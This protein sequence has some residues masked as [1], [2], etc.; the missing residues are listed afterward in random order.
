MS[1]H[2]IPP[3][4]LPP[5]IDSDQGPENWAPYK[6]RLQFEVADFLYHCNQMSGG[7]IN[8]VLNLWAVSLAIHDDDPPF[9][10]A[11]HMYDTINSTP[12]GEV[13]WESFTLQYDGPQPTEN[14]PSWMDSEY[15]I[16]FQNPLSLVHNILSNPEFKSGF[17]YSPFQERTSHGADIIAEDPEMH[18]LVFCPIILGSDKTTILVAR[19]HNEY[20][21]VYLSIGNICNNFRRV[22]CNGVVFLGF[23][24]IPKKNH[25]DNKDARFH[26]FCCQ[27]F[28]S[29]LAKILVSLKPSMT[30]PNIARFPD[31]HYRKTVY[32]LGPYIAD[33]PEQALLACTVQGWC[34]KCT[35]PAKGLDSG[36]HVCCSQ[37][38]SELLVE[39]FELGT[40]W[41]EYGLVGDPF[42]SDFPHAD[43]NELL[44]PDLLHQL[45]KGAFKDHLITWVNNYI[46]VEYPESQAWKILDDI[47]WHIALA[48]SFAW[49]RCFP[50]GRNFKQWTGDDSKALMKVYLPA[51]EGHVL[52]QMVQAMRTF[53]EFCYIARRDVHDTHSIKA[54]EDALQ[55]FHHHRK[56][57]QETGAHT[58]GFDNLPRQHLLVHD[59]RLIRAF[60]A[61]NG[62]CSSIMESKHIKA[63][64][65]P[66]QC[67]N[68]FEVLTQMLLTNQHLDKLAASRVNFTKCGMLEGM[69]L[70]MTWEQILGVFFNHLLT[71][72]RADTLCKV[73]PNDMAAELEGPD[74]TDLIQQ[75]IRDQEHPELDFDTSL[76][77]LPSFYGKIIVYPSAVATFY[78][79]SDLSGVGGMRRE[80]LRA[81][82]SWRNG[83]GHYDTVF[84][85][86]D[87][88]KTGMCGLSVAR[89]R[90]FFSFTHGGVQY[91]CTLVCWLSR[92]GDS[93]D[94]NTGMWVVEEMDDDGDKSPVAI[95]HLDTIVHAAHL[96]PVFGSEQVS[97]TLSFTDTLDIFTSF[98]VNK[99]TDHH[100][101]K[102]AF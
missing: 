39:E 33:Y 69:C 31:G 64:K 102:I 95:L 89:V 12:L 81:V 52:D 36:K 50:E 100:S 82:K 78:A 77:D 13:P 14:I 37:A 11:Q 59:M 75:F 71:F 21:P 63:M 96:L 28:H 48:P 86:T 24:A 2:F 38:H 73:Y 98:Y 66:W 43:I 54:L 34:P 35:A 8:F 5:A 57:F 23:L 51:I 56:I 26:K 9:S 47:D 22:H 70:L 1:S 87:P 17:D 62:L 15:D 94:G 25:V 91:P 44:S 74:F 90:L 42:T 49:L 99:Y 19:G 65:E 30:V 53:L 58:K 55:R 29:S 16:W 67:S 80:C 101:F 61:P 46:K 45:I 93:S 84:I 76:A 7:N 20:W 4:S 85:N 97:P 60:G 18:G 92:M 88:A 40:L 10:N 41:D 83:P 27:L 3:D 32:G 79:P 72:I 6:N 68:R